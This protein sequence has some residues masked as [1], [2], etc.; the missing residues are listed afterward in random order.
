MVVARKIAGSFVVFATTLPLAVFIFFIAQQQF[1]R[2]QMEEKLETEQLTS[3]TISAHNFKW[4]K[5]GK[6]IIVNNH[7]F[8]V[9]SITRL[10]GDQLLIKGLYDYQEQKLHKDLDDWMN[11]KGS[12]SKQDQHVFFKWLSQLYD[13]NV[14]SLV[15]Y[16]SNC[17]AL[18][19]QLFHTSPFKGI[20]LSVLTPPPRLMFC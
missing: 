5:E 3:V 17:I 12:S 6:E 7:L 10:A 19:H 4:Y 8:D 14:S 18:N 2:W 20:T 1:M 13:D 9:K 11:N 15:L 16:S